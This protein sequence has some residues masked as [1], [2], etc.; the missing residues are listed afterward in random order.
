MAERYNLEITPLAYQDIDQAL[1]YI[2]TQLA[3]P[4]SAAKLY[5]KIEQKIESI[6]VFPYACP[7]CVYYFIPDT[8]YRHAVIGNYLLTFRVKEASHTVQILRF[9]YAR[10]DFSVLSHV[11]D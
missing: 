10:R 2:R 1:D 4:K 11:I 9:V 6:R 7:D 5:K 3:N 8:S